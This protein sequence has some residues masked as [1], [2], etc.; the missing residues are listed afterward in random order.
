MKLFEY[1]NL[2]YTGFKKLKSQKT[3]EDHNKFWN[4]IVERL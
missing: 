1:M 4:I 3:I 2:P